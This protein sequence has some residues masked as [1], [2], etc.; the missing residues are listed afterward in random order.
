MA[1]AW[2]GKAPAGLEAAAVRYGSGRAPV[3][4]LHTYTCM[5]PQCYAVSAQGTEYLTGAQKTSVYPHTQ[6]THAATGCCVVNVKGSESCRQ[7]AFRAASVEGH[8][9]CGPP[10]ACRQAMD[11]QER[12][13]CM[14]VCNMRCMTSVAMTISNSITSSRDFP[15][16]R[17]MRLV[18]S[19]A[20]QLPSGGKQTLS[21]GISGLCT[22]LC[23]RKRREGTDGITAKASVELLPHG[24]AASSL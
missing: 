18:G 6:H 21:G 19:N 14:C 8:K 13:Q 11:E 22:H 2:P 20:V 10:A 7:R 16:E 9:P 3:R 23:P 24:A 5:Q 15:K 12:C 4:P 17:G 1:A